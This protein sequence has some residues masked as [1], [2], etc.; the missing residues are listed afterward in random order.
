LE[1]THPTATDDYE[2]EAYT[3]AKA[4]GKP[5]T[6][7]NYD[8]SD[9]KDSES[10]DDY[11]DERTG[12]S[13]FPGS[14]HYDHIPR[15][16]KCGVIRESGIV[17]RLV[18]ESDGAYASVH[19]FPWQAAILQENRKTYVFRCSGVLVDERRIVTT[20]HNMQQIQANSL[21]VRLGEHDLSTAEEALFQPRD[22][23]VDQIHLH[24]DFNH[25]TMA[26]DVAVLCIRPQKYTRHVAP[27]CLP[28][29]SK[30]NFENRQCAV[31]GWGKDSLGKCIRSFS[32]DDLDRHHR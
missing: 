23:P 22:N 20:A 32:T 12:E 10:D 2:E 6:T 19:E 30:Q 28:R 29:N 5:T 1:A 11:A 13:A 21:I 17:R 18:A 16:D 15:N 31:S 24:P 27:I 3:Q 9:D 14:K 26:N 7:A 4:K 25:E 8:S